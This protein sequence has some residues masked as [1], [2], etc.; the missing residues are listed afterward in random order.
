M[1]GYSAMSRTLSVPQTSWRTA[2]WPQ[3]SGAGLARA[4]TTDGVFNASSGNFGPDAV[5]S[6]YALTPGADRSYFQRIL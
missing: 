1:A 4:A 2:I 6:I 3:L 5:R